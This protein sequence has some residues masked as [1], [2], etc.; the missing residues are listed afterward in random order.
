M[1]LLHLGIL[2]SGR[3]VL[4]DVKRR[5]MDQSACSLSSC[6]SSA[7]E[8]RAVFGDLSRHRPCGVVVVLEL[9]HGYVI[10]IEEGAC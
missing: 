10:L 4:R 6:N 2:L 1:H 5:W 9:L 7:T 3:P 8:L